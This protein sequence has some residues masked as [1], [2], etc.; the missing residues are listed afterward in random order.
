MREWKAL[1]STYVSVFPAKSRRRCGKEKRNWKPFVRLLVDDGRCRWVA[2][3]QQLLRCTI[4][5]VLMYIMCTCIFTC[6]CASCTLRL[7]E[8]EE[9]KYVHPS[10][11]NGDTI[12]AVFLLFGNF[13]FCWCCWCCYWCWFHQILIFGWKFVSFFQFLFFIQLV[14]VLVSYRR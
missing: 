10:L 4:V 12:V 6:A 7:G 11:P 14:L 9:E 1:F 13:G 3:S 2:S 5:F 8:C